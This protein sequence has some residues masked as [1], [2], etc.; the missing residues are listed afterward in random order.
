MS[1]ELEE[2]SKGLLALR[3]TIDDVYSDFSMPY[4]YI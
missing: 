3:A 4:T 2:S 1:M